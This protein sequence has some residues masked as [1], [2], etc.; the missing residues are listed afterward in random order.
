MFD[1]FV[2]LLICLG[3]A[4]LLAFAIMIQMDIVQMG[5]L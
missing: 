3:V 4:V 1:R 2:D 5:G